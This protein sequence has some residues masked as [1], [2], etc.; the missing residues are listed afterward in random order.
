MTTNPQVGTASTFDYFETS[1]E[2]EKFTFCPPPEAPVFHPT[3]EE[4]K[5][6]LKYIAT[7]KPIAIHSGICKIIPPEVVFKF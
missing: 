6:P 4:F 1:E 5:D 7:I 3:L 2:S